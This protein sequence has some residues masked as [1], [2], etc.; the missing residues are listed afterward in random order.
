MK[1]YRAGAP[2]CL[3]GKACGRAAFFRQQPE[4]NHPGLWLAFFSRKLKKLFFLLIVNCKTT[5]RRELPFSSSYIPQPCLPLPQQPA[6]HHRPIA[7]FQ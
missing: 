3:Y 5:E 1:E 4:N 7:A 6:H 2:K